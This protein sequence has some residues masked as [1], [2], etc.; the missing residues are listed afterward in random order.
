MGW[1]RK[2]FGESSTY[3]GLAVLSVLA[4]SLIPAGALAQA[5]TDAAPYVGALAAMMA[6]GKA[7]KGG[8]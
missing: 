2:R 6:M 8:K 5:A 4:E 1:L 7:E 3:A